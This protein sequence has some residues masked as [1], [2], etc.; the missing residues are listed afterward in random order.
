[1]P[2]TLARCSRLLYATAFVR[3]FATGMVAIVLAG[4]LADRGFAAGAVG[5]VVAAGLAGNAVALAVTSWVGDRTDARRALL[6]LGA[7]W[8]GGAML[9]AIPSSAVVSALAA[10]VGM[11]DGM[12]RDRGAA[13]ALEQ[14]LLPSTTDDARR[15][16][17][18]AWYNAFQDAGHALGALAAGA[19]A[20]SPTS[21]SIGSAPLSPRLP[22]SS[23]ARASRTSSR[24]SGPRCSRDASAS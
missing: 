4:Y 6:L 24:I 21:S 18:F 10:F 3:A 15:T 9:I 2:T 16:R 11:V 19:P 22:F 1:M 7:L 5:V 23:S 14:A 8:C 13:L 12:G 17:A 20:L